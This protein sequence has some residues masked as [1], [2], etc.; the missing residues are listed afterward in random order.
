M[1]PPV[2]PEL[3]RP[4]DDVDIQ[5]VDVPVERRSCPYV[6]EATVES[7][8]VPERLRLVEKRLVADSPVVEAFVMLASVE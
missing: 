8:N 2:T 4:S 5:R 3:I 6:P 1:A 7:R